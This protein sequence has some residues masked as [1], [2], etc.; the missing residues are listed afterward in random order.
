M[1]RMRHVGRGLQILGLVVLP[2]SMVLELTN[3]LGRFYVS[4]MVTMLVFGAAAFT[5]GWFIESYA[6]R[7]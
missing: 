6:R 2:L 3:H 5:L 7:A 4:N 1:E